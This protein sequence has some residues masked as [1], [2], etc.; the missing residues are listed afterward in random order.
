MVA[1]PAAVALACNAGQIYHRGPSSEEGRLGDGHGNG[2]GVSLNGSQEIGV[3][4]WPEREEL[5]SLPIQRLHLGSPRRRGDSID[6]GGGHGLDGEG[7]GLGGSPLS[8]S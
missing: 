4:D 7:L 8:M 1:S 6:L 5:G 2:M 3:G